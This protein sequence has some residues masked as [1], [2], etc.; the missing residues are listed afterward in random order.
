MPVMIPCRRY[1]FSIAI[2]TG[3]SPFELRPTKGIVNPVLTA[4]DVSDVPADFVADPFIVRNGDQW[5]LFFE[6]MNAESKKGQIAVANSSDGY[7]W[8]YQ[9]IVLDEPFHLSYPYVFSWKGDYY[10]I[11]ESNQAGA[12][13]LYKAV[14]FPFDW[15]FVK[16]LVEGVALVDASPFFFA[17][18]WWLF[19]GSGAPTN[20]FS[21]DLRLFYA[22]DLMGPWLEHPK[23]PVIRGDAHIARPS[24]RVLVIDG[25][26]YRLA[27]DC[28]PVYGKSVNAFEVTQLT[29]KDYQERKVQNEP[30][31]EPGGDGW[32]ATGMHHIDAQLMDDGKWLACVDGWTWVE[33]DGTAGMRD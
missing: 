6:V 29:E 8:N 13:R 21:Q 10:M 28:D 12:V 20:W 17:D 15:S 19:A 25:K 9:R 33:M 27:Q 1:V 16:N 18:K 7:Q 32:N 23:S 22:D 2:Y 14:N 3:D 30:I 11:P 5:Y 4:K 26:V 31:L 24:G